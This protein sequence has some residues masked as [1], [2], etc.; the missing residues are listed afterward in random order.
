M[1]WLSLCLGWGVRSDAV[2]GGGEFNRLWMFDYRLIFQEVTMKSEGCRE[3][4]ILSG[5]YLSA[6]TYISLYI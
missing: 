4:D 5:R 1:R 3:F 6:C 2:G